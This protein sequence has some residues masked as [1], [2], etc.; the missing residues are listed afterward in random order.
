MGKKKSPKNG[1]FIQRKT[2]IKKKNRIFAVTRMNNSVNNKDQFGG[3]KKENKFLCKN[4]I[5]YVR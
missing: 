5:H 4:K 3:K 2:E 1:N